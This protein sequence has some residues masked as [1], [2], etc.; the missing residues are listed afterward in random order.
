MTSAGSG[1]STYAFAGEWQDSYIKLLYL[2]ARWYGGDTGRFTTRDVWPPDYTRPQSL[3]GWA[4]VEGNPI[5]RLDPS[6]LSSCNTRTCQIMRNE[7]KPHIVAAARRFN[8]RTFTNMTDEGFAAMLGAKLLFENAV[9]CNEPSVIGGQFSC[10]Q[11]SQEIAQEVLGAGNLNY[12]LYWRQRDLANDVAP[13]V[14]GITYGRANVNIQQSV[15]A[16]LWW[17][18]LGQNVGAYQG[19]GN[20]QSYNT[21]ATALV[22][23]MNST[24]WYLWLLAIHQSETLALMD[25]RQGLERQ[26]LVMTHAGFLSY[27]GVAG[28]PAN[29]RNLCWGANAGLPTNEISAFRIAVIVFG[30]YGQVDVANWAPSGSQS[31][32][33][34]RAAK[35]VRLIPTAS[36]MLDLNAREGVDYHSYTALDA[37]ILQ[38][39]NYDYGRE[40]LP[41]PR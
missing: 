3:N 7:L 27:E 19:V 8:L 29:Q 33:I 24:N 41:N 14:A 6:G 16:Q 28:A 21:V 1:T 40:F 38:D 30:G 26:A 23:S 15:Q 18:A 9:T 39:L 32:V 31:D 37:L 36:G 22:G 20:Y 13:E 10:L 5:N 34:H 4:Y 11:Y 17:Q 35:W 25:D 2:R 12:E